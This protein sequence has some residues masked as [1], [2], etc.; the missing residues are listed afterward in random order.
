MRLQGSGAPVPQPV[1]SSGQLGKEQTLP[2]AADLFSRCEVGLV[3]MTVSR[4]DVTESS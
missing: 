2:C 3:S 1:G 4:V